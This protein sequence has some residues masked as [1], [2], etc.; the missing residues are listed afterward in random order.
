[1]SLKH[2]YLVAVTAIIAC[3]PASGTSGPSR[4]STDPR[5]ANFLAAEEILAAN[6]DVMTAYDALARL[7]PNWLKAHGVSSFDPRGSDFA[8]VFVDGQQY[9]GLN[10][11]RNIPA[12]QVADFRY[13][14]VTEAGGTF[15][16]KGGTGGV[17]EVRTKVAINPSRSR[18][19][20]LAHAGEEGAFWGLFLTAK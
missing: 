13:Y 19:N 8:I 17:I 15:G 3:A 10:S 16:L 9:G 4:I 11:L 18:R 2:L 5:R 12:N 6:A 7:R 1:M 14:D 20:P